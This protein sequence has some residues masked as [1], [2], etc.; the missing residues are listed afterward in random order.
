MKNL[1]FTEAG[2]FIEIFLRKRLKYIFLQRF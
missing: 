2:F 1:P